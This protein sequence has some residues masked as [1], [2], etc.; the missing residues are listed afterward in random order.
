MT[1]MERMQAHA[2][3]KTQARERVLE[4]MDARRRDALAIRR[5]TIM[6]TLVAAQMASDEAHDV[7]DGDM[8][9]YARYMADEI[10]EAAK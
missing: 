1:D 5:E 8:V 3:L 7:S 4:E 6:A 2:D 9:K 10:M